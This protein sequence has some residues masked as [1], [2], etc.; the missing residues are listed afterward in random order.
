M[1]LI[2]GACLIRW[3]EAS[4]RT[5]CELCQGPFLVSR[6][7]PVP[8]DLAPPKEEPEGLLPRSEDIALWLVV[9]ILTTVLFL[10]LAVEA[11][12]RAAA[13]LDRGQRVVSTT[14]VIEF[15]LAFLVL[16]LSLLLLYKGAWRAYAWCWILFIW[17]RE[18]RE[19]SAAWRICW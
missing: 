7:E 6:P 4:Q 10:C 15:A 17:P 19:R 12:L 13:E 11:G 5:T 9:H 3:I 14:V 18:D 8:G 16:A 2:H 1:G